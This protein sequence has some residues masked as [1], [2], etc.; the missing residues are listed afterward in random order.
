MKIILIKDIE[1]L[2]KCGEVVEVRDGYA[3]NYLIPQGFA[4]YASKE[5]FQRLER[6]KKEERKILERK[7]KQSLQ[8]K[9]KIEKLSLTIPVEVKEGEDIYGSV[10]SAQISKLLKSEGIEIEENKIILAEPIRK[11]GVY[12]IEIELHPQVKGSLRVWV[13]K[14]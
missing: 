7:K 11:L 5:N 13:V 4:L 10:G 2:G 8:L 3:R 9:E 6:I 14:K 1:K 12:S